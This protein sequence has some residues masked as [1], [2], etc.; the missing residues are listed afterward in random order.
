MHIAVVG[1][2]AL[3][4][5][6]GVRLATR[7]AVDVTFVVRPGRSPHPLR[8]SRIDGDGASDELPSPATDTRIP[9]HTDAVLV[10]VR[11]EQLDASLDALLVAA[12]GIPIVMLTPLLPHDWE[13]LVR[14]H[15]S[16]L[17]AAIPGVVAYMTDDGRLRYWLPRL[18][19]TLIDQTSPQPPEITE[20]VSALCRAG[21]PA[22]TEL[23]VRETNPAITLSFVPLMMGIDAAGGIDALM[24]ESEL[25][26]TVLDAVSEARVLAS[27]IGKAPAWV[28]MLA[29]FLGPS[30]LKV[31]L[32]L[33]RRRSP[34]ALAY[35]E[36]HFGRKLHA[37][38]VV[39]ARAIVDLCREKG[40]RADALSSLLTRL[41]RVPAG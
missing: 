21:L 27:T 33:A 32:V 20:L 37:Q 8:L 29:A 30:M 24:A 11:A 34:E 3:G 39:M 6:Y 40:T 13:R 2:G 10:C 1:M 15:G 35:V 25:L 26:R 28:D 36:D 31:G 14:T 16:R 7:A 4:C 9:E 41:E 38:N 17:L 22:R 23:G 12:P 5:V 19:P 18:A